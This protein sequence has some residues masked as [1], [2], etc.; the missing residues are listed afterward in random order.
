MTTSPESG[1]AQGMDLFGNKVT[2]ALEE[3]KKKERRAQRQAAAAWAQGMTVFAENVTAAKPY[4]DAIKEKPKPKDPQ[5][6]PTGGDSAAPSDDELPEKSAEVDRIGMP[7]VSKTVER[8]IERLTKELIKD[9]KSIILT[10]VDYGSIDFIPEREIEL[11]VDIDFIRD[12]FNNMI[13]LVKT[14]L[15][16][17]TPGRPRTSEYIDY[18]NLF[19]VRYNTSNGEPEINLNLEFNGYGAEDLIINK[20]S[21]QRK[22]SGD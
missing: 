14:K 13:D 22:G 3:E 5:I 16:P 17:G 7:N 6:V 20:I 1:W 15:A 8:E 11:A 2:E 4:V 12:S 18:F 10:D 19:S 9:M 21:I